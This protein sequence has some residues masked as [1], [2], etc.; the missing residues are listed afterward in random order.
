VGAVVGAMIKDELRARMGKK[1]A[2][3]KCS[4]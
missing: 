1:T 4:L 2:D 3:K